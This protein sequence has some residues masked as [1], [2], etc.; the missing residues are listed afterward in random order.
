[1]SLWDQS[2][3]QV[4]AMLKILGNHGVVPEELEC[5]RQDPD[6]IGKAV[7]AELKKEVIKR[8][9]SIL[10][11]DLKVDTLNGRYAILKATLLS[12]SHD[13]NQLRDLYKN[14][15]LNNINNFNISIFN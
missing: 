7:A 9:D 1:M 15:N 13:L 2:Y 10:L 8:T 14:I 4:G 3:G 5:L 11:L 6:R 12:Q